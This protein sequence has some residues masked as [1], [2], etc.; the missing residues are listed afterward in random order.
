MIE[1]WVCKKCNKKWIYPVEK[2]VYCFGKIES[3]VGNKMKVVGF[4]HV[5]IPSPMHP[6][7]PYNVLVLEDEN[8]N[9]MP[10]KTM[11]MD[12]KIGDE[13][14]FN[15]STDPHAVSIVKIKYNTDLAVKQAIDYIGGLKVDK[16]TKIMLIPNILMP[17]N[18]YLGVTTHPLVVAAVVKYLVEHG[19]SKDNIV[20]AARALPGLSTEKAFKKSGIAIT[21]KKLGINSKHVEKS[22]GKFK[23]NIPEELF[24]QDLI[25]NIP[26]L[27]TH[28]QL[29]VSAALE[30]M[31][32]VVDA[33]TLY[34]MYAINIHE[35]IAHLNKIVPKYF[36]VADA[37]KGMH[38]KGP[39][40]DGEPVFFNCVT[41]SH[42]PVAHDR[43]YQ[44]MAMLK[45][46]D[47]IKIA[48][49]EGVGERDLEK[50]P[51]C[52]DELMACKMEVKRPEG[53]LSNHPTVEIIDG[54]S[55]PMEVGMVQMVLARLFKHRAKK[56][57]V[58]VGKELTKEMF[59][60]KENI[61]A[62]GDLAIN[63]LK[64]LGIK[65]I[66][67]IPGKPPQPLDVG[68][69]LKE[70]LGAERKVSSAQ[71]A[72]IEVKQGGIKMD[73]KGKV[74]LVTGA[75]QGIGKAIA[76]KL[77]SRGANIVVNDIKSAIN[78]AV[79]TVEEIKKFGVDAISVGA[80]VAD[81]KEVEAMYEI[82]KEKFGKVDIIVNNAGITRDKTL[83][84]MDKD[85]W[86]SVIGVNLTGIYNVSKLGLEL[87][88]EGGRIIS[89]SSIVGQRGNFGQ[90]NYSASKAGIIG[91]TR[92]LAKELGKKKITVNAIAPGFVESR[93]TAMIPEEMQKIM[94]RLI[95]LGRFAQPE[96]VANVVAFLASPDAA[97]VSG[98]TVNVDGAMSL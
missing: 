29:Q 3:E 54:L 36:T 79:V 84:K 42:D 83:K 59:E 90:T 91:F 47:Y 43:T 85:M 64:E 44:E 38:G 26:G 15:T 82:V 25:V 65:T 74:A 18:Y 12:Y 92:S 56:I 61:V 13:F 2:C 45:E 17:A 96:E 7:V 35:A 8:G 87:I 67:D 53:S 14:K 19:A 31:S 98:C 93:M 73:L 23:F 89:I 32:R 33:K 70:L 49:K 72:S 37:I 5:K 66:K 10:K 80:N 41:A 27:K 78:N 58:A 97:Y 34:M 24:N 63:K 6:F 28:A 60:G 75:S 81:Y 68:G 11:N 39:G 51:D 50:I 88:P 95:G 69:T 94:K 40:L 55:C 62:V 21:C 4:T 22:S 20:V 71:K 76:L 57:T 30:N 86:E 1:R 52:C 46:P 16:D 77:A 48:A 9:R